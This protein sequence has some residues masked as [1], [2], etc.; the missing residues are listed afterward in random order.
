M[1]SSARGGGVKAMG[2]G[3]DGECGE[4]SIPGFLPLIIER[5]SCEQKL[6]KNNEK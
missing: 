3:E 4:R 5:G 2:E 1:P 6:F